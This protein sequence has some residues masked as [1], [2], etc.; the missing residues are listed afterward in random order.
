MTR[1]GGEI[2]GPVP[3]G[4]DPDA[5]DRLRRRVLWSLPTGLYVLGS[6]A[7]NGRNLMT[8][9]WVSQVALEPK[10]IGVGVERTARTH[11]LLAA[12]G[13]F[14]LSLLARR[15]RALVRHFVKPVQDIDVDEA[16]GIGTMNGTA[17]RGAATGAPI[18]EVA[19]AWLDCEIR[20]TLPVGSHTW[21]V[22][23]VVDA[24][25]SEPETD[26]TAAD[27]ADGG[28]LR[29]EDTRLNYGG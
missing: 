5:Y 4:R 1:P 13:V 3:D 9:S 22:G 24:G 28:L 27:A 19:A 8:V 16:S 14:A 20:H 26:D 29:M 7:G 10:L 25:M 15:D 17:V 12:G 23:E 18:L 11:E 2:V 6:R 21:F